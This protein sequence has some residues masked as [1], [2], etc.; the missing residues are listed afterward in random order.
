MP[1]PVPPSGVLDS[2][3]CSAWPQV[4]M[5]FFMEF[6]VHASSRLTS[7]TVRE[8]WWLIMAV[9]AWGLLTD[10]GSSQKQI[11]P[12]AGP[13]L[14]LTTKNLAPTTHARNPGPQTQNVFKPTTP[15]TAT[16]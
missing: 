14:T 6:Q 13:T 10:R 2:V 1:Q 16:T 15:L 3:A 9:S 12:N 11:H 4:T 5:A 7:T 8:H